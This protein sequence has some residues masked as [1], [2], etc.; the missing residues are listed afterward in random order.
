MYNNNGW[1]KSEK[2]NT[3]YPK[4]RKRDAQ[5]HRL[6]PDFRNIPVNSQPNWSPESMVSSGNGRYVSGEIIFLWQERITFSIV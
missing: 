4:D 2:E 1:L 5:R 3:L 6:G